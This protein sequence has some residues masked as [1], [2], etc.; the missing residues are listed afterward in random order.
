MPDTLPSPD[1]PDT[2]ACSQAARRDG[3]RRLRLRRAR[4]LAL[5]FGGAGVFQR[6]EPTVRSVCRIVRQLVAEL[7]S[8]SN[9]RV[10]RRRHSRRAAA[11]TRQ[12]AMYVCHVALQISLADIGAAFGRDRT[13]VGHACNVVE[14]RRDDRA[15]DDF[16]ATVERITLTVFGTMGAID[17]E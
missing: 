7:L 13:T 15:F 10:L 9:E 8:L 3:K 5:A 6:C 1:I 2:P 17:H 11:H 16:V 12:I 14:D 4:L